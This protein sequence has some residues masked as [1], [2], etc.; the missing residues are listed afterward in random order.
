MK[1]STQTPKEIKLPKTF[2][3]TERQ[4][5]CIVNALDILS[6]MTRV[7]SDFDDDVKQTIAGIHSFLNSNGLKRK[8]K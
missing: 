6:A 5:N 7:E 2:K 1:D 8:H 4:L 3:I